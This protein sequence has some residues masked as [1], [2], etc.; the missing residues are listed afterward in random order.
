MSG[1]MAKFYMLVG[2][3][4]LL[5]YL[6]AESRGFV[7]WPS[8]VRS[9]IAPGARPAGGRTGAYVGGYRGGK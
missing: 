7:F 4:V 6:V 9:V 1:W 3:V 2:G 8:D 5:G